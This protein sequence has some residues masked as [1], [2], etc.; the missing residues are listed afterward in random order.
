MSSKIIIQTTYVEA[1]LLLTIPSDPVKAAIIVFEFLINYFDYKSRA[2]LHHGDERTSLWKCCH[3]DIQASVFAMHCKR[4]ERVYQPFFVR[5][6]KALDEEEPQEPKPSAEYREAIVDRKP[7]YFGR[8]ILSSAADGEALLTEMDAKQAAADAARSSPSFCASPKLSLQEAKEARMSARRARMAALRAEHKEKWAAAIQTDE[9][10]EDEFAFRYGPED[11]VEGLNHLSK[12]YM[13]RARNDVTAFQDVAAVDTYKA[14]FERALHW[15]RHDQYEPEALKLLLLQNVNP[16][17]LRTVLKED[18]LLTYDNF[19]TS[20]S[21]VYEKYGGYLR[22]LTKL[23]FDTTSETE[24]IDTRLP[25]ALVPGP[26]PE[27]IRFAPAAPATL[28]PERSASPRAELLCE[29]CQRTGHVAADCFVKKHQIATSP[30]P[31]VYHTPSASTPRGPRPSPETPTATPAGHSGTPPSTPPRALSPSGHS[32]QD[33]DQVRQLSSSGLRIRYDAPHP[34]ESI[35]IQS[36][37][38]TRPVLPPG[39]KSLAPSFPPAVRKTT[40]AGLRLVAD[41]EHGPIVDGI[42]GCTNP[43]CRRSA[44]A[45][46]PLRV[47]LRLDTGCGRKSKDEELNIVPAAWLEVL[48]RRGIHPRA[49]PAIEATS[50]LDGLVKL[51]DTAVDISIEIPGARTGPSVIMFYIDFDWLHVMGN[52]VVGMCI[53]SRQRLTDVG[54]I[55][56]YQER[57][58]EPAA[59]SPASQVADGPEPVYAAQPTAGSAA[60][61]N[62]DSDDVSD[63]IDDELSANFETNVDPLPVQVRPEEL[64]S[65]APRL[66]LATGPT[67]TYA[68]SRPSRLS[69][70]TKQKRRQW[71]R[72]RRR[73]NQDFALPAAAT[74]RVPATSFASLA[75][76]STCSLVDHFSTALDYGVCAATGHSASVPNLVVQAPARHP[77]QAPDQVVLVPAGLLATAPDL[78]VLAPAGLL[79][80]APDPVVRAPV[81]L[82]AAPDLVVRAP[83]GLL[84]AAPDLVVRAP[85]DRSA[86]APDLF[87]I[88]PACKA[89]DLVVRAPAR[90]SATAPDLV[91]RAPV[92]HSAAEPDRVFC[93]PVGY[94][95]PAP[96]QVD[97]APASFPAQAPSQEPFAPVGPTPTFSVNGLES[98]LAPPPGFELLPCALRRSWPISCAPPPVPKMPGE[99]T[100][101]S[102][103]N[104]AIETGPTPVVV[105]TCAEPSSLTLLW[106]QLNS[107]IDTAPERHADIV[108][109]ST[110]LR[111]KLVTQTG[112]TPTLV[113]TDKISLLCEPTSDYVTSPSAAAYSILRVIVTACTCLATA[114]PSRA[115]YLWSPRLRGR[116]LRRSSVPESPSRLHRLSVLPLPVRLPRRQSHAATLGVPRPRAGAMRAQPA[117]YSGRT[118]DLLPIW[119]NPG[120]VTCHKT[121]C[122][123]CARCG[124]ESANATAFHLPLFRA[125]NTSCSLQIPE[126][127][128]RFWE[129]WG[130]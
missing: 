31:R 37:A 49:A 59:A 97:P 13:P 121:F 50:A 41:D 78:V 39:S 53:L 92:D 6:Q 51:F 63:D 126:T 62:N 3:R 84:A 17:A 16:S 85:A 21:T 73:A 114:T 110:V 25:A 75:A 105:T 128:F 86:A 33:D 115:A 43:P 64:C 118:K 58:A 103:L 12:I 67:P 18:K 72:T 104:L 77:A 1:P 61:A 112:P 88:A 32:R 34:E 42:V 10:M 26:A 106:A 80:T 40:Y 120:I 5:F 89:P 56:R 90:L 81:G 55:M 107:A 23:G 27:S 46:S 71:H 24:P 7:R 70:L 82:A 129:I 44:R 108:S 122:P 66:N 87:V 124:H 69:Q 83:V 30:A 98:Q 130:G 29:F 68:A 20:L 8:R 19:W 74:V 79:A 109:T 65:Q 95:A 101:S 57:A 94:L 47:R 96:D 123:I 4:M 125:A 45:S 60:D 52:F 127:L 117:K 35:A 48:A 14:R 54:E 9:V 116:L 76:A 102:R 119:F 2:V 99:S 36:I 28:P 91:V 22:L 15:C 93:A 111:L 11:P 113:A 38:S 100:A